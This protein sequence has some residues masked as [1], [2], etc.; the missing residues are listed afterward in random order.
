MRVLLTGGSGDLGKIL[1]AQLVAR[2]DQPVNLDLR[3]PSEPNGAFVEGSV[4]DRKLLENILPGIDSIVHIAAWHG[5]HEFRGD[6]NA[7]EFWDLNV[8]GTFNILE[9]CAQAKKNKFIFIS[10]TS[11]DDWPGVY[12]H[13]K[14]I[15]EDLMRT[16]VAR[17]G[18]N[19]VTLR[20]RAFIPHWNRSVYA[21]FAEWARWFWKGSVHID[22]VAQ[23]VLKSIDALEH[24][25]L[26]E[27]SVLTIDGA[28]DFLKQELDNWDAQGPGSTFKKRFGE[29]NYKLA[30]RNKLNPALK[31]NI[32]GYED[33]DRLIGY[34]PTYGFGS[35]LK[36]LAAR[37]K[38][39]SQT[40]AE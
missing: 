5:I 13:S 14:I 29:E 6:K 10:S 35:M 15:S 2:G 37:E 19:I 32:L 38:F 23:A 31:P 25:L 21:T 27:H 1:T 20:P 28:C 40:I 34:K 8:N 30:M 7:F 33:A 24:R 22:D 39:Q 17:H 12:A 11:I 36:E 4:T 26:K 16:Y 3:Q 18:M 9:C